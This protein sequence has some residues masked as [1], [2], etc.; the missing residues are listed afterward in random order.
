MNWLTKAISLGEKIKKVQKRPSKRKLKFGQVI[1]KVQF[2]KDLE[3]NL[4]HA[5]LWQHH[6]ISCRH[7]IFFEKFYEIIETPQ[8]ADDPLNWVDTKSYKDRLKIARKKQ[9]KIVL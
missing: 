3:N 7:L 9:I 1:V 2:K 6:R 4:W 8:P 5:I